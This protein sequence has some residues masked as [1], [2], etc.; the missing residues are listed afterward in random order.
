MYQVFKTLTI[1]K[2]I[3][4]K[5]LCKETY[6][7]LKSDKKIPRCKWQYNDSKLDNNIS[8]AKTN[9]FSICSF[10]RFSYFFTQTISSK[11]D[12]SDLKSLIRKFA[13]I[14][15]DCR[16]A[17]PEEQ[18]FY[19]FIPE[20]H[21]D[22]KNW[23]L[24]GFL[25]G[26]YKEYVYTNKNGYMSLSCFDKI[27]FNSISAIKNY[28]ACVQYATKYITKGLAGSIKKG[29]KLYYSTHGLQK[30]NVVYK[31]TLTQ[32]APIHYDYA[33]E[34][35]LKTTLDKNKYYNLI[36]KIDNLNLK[37]YDYLREDKSILNNIIAQNVS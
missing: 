32:I 27:G 1:D 17:F 34:Y 21:L 35:V 18:F 25:S 23:H 37:V 33:N 13:Q 36:T 12:R 9:I 16:K 2:T 10:N 7:Y 31:S 30:S 20:Y 29:E 26:G 15:R 24:H 14:T 19:L 4:G 6:E 11:F 22:G 28:D 5:Y 3:Y 8:R